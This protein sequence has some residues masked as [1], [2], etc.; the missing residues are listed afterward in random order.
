M[1]SLIGISAVGMLALASAAQ[2]DLISYWNFNNFGP[3]SSAGTPAALGITSIAASSGFGAV[4]LASY[5]GNIDDFNGSTINALNGDP[6][7]AS[8]SL[9]A[10]GSSPFPGN[11]SSI[12]FNTDLAAFA[13]P[14][15]SFATQRT[16]TGFNSVQLA[17]STDGS[18]FTNFGG[19]YPASSSFYIHSF[20]RSSITALD[21]ASNAVFRL[22]FSGATSS[23]GN[24]RIDNLQ[25]NATSVP[26]PAAAALMG[27]GGLFI[28]R[29]RR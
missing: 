9:I 13:D 3:I 4:N 5:A 2:A 29:R 24:N 15:I 17:Y 21:G 12:T 27:L 19:A 16:G 28:G 26:A 6:S 10:G 20:H 8:L 23:S 25:I 11:G 1:K 22:T 7:G 14:I 18:N